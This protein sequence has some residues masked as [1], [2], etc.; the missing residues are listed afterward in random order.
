M[1]PAT[2]PGPDIPEGQATCGPS[3]LGDTLVLFD[4]NGTLADDTDRA[5]R[6]TNAVLA[7]R[8]LPA[9]TT[10]GFRARWKLPMRDFLTGLDVA[11][12]QAGEHHWNRAVADEPAPVR[13]H[14]AAVLDALRGRGALLG[15]I[16][17][18]GHDAVTADLRRTGLADRFDVVL[19]GCADKTA[20]L[21]GQRHLRGGAIYIGDTEYDIHCARAAG[22]HA[23]GITGGYREPENLR[24]ARPD[25]LIESL[26]ELAPLL[27][28]LT[29]R[30]ATA[31]GGTRA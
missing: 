16:S 22:Y 14:A 15:V 29:R 7:A 26:D 3:D 11:D 25:A 5:V 21:R 13:G 28:D 17:A 19:T 18:A 31:P 27:G 4:W 8:G 12:P 6:A 20:A 9:L 10:E 30:S 23:V 2:H 1:S 24:A